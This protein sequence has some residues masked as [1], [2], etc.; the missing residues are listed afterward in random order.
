MAGRVFAD[1]SAW[2]AYFVY[3]DQWHGPASI[4]LDQIIRSRKRLLTT[5]DVF[6]ETVTS[7]RRVAGY[8]RGVEAGEILRG[9]S[10]AEV[11][12][13]DDSL[14]EKAWALFRKYKIP[15]LSLTDCTSFAAMEKYGIA[16]A[17]T[18]D[19]DFRKAGFK[20]L[21]PK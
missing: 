16:E 21:P 10:L 12:A 1:T 6:D 5:S 13:I 7:I 3:D 18:F 15:G 11:A 17:F 8:D 2:V 14:R 4:C 9:S 20:T 19:E